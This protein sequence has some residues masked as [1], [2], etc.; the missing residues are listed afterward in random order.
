MGDT[1]TGSGDSSRES[2]RAPQ[3]ALARLARWIGTSKLLSAPR[4]IAR[5]TVEKYFASKDIYPVFAYLPRGRATLQLI[6]QVKSETGMLLGDLEAFEICQAVKRSE[7]IP[8]EIAEVGVFRGGS[9]K[10]IAETSSKKIH[11]FD[12]FEGLPELTAEDDP[13]QFSKDD[14]SASLESVEEYMASYPHVSLYKGVFPATAGPVE[15]SK[16]SFVH[17]DV[18]LYEPTL[19][20]LRFFY[21]RMSRGGV[22]I[23]HDYRDIPQFH[24]S[25][26][27]KAFDEFFADK[28][29][30]VIELLDGSQCLVVK[31]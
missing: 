5:L 27:K 2:A 7:K 22:I 16:F 25:G 14:Y 29:E 15:T 8:G 17:L 11:L 20:S 28:P 26:V 4:R 6:A 13:E 19:E 9:A 18:D 23:G 21:P 30:I 12:T 1:A 31:V 10:L 3:G 24:D